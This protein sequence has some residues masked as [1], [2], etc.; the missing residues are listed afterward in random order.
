MAQVYNIPDEVLVLAAVNQLK[1]HAIE[2]YNRQ[3][4]GSVA[5]WNEFQF[6]IRRYFERK[7]SYTV[8]SARVSARTWRAYAEK[9][10]DYA[11]DKLK[12]M[13]F[14]TLTEEE[15]IE[16]LA[17]G[18]REPIL[19][20]L[21]LNS[22]AATVPDFIEQVRKIT[23]DTRVVPEVPDLTYIWRLLFKKITMVESTNL[24]KLKFEV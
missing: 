23:E 24:I 19:R 17:D 18:V 5:T 6:Q 21:V 7:I 14:L 8:T 15:Q 4:L 11:E 20:K 10:I 1:G 12:L 3:P 13:Q 2:W 16:L 9:F 22:G